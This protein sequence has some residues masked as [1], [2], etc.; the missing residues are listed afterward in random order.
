M[1]RKITLR[2]KLKR[3]DIVRTRQGEVLGIVVRQETFLGSKGHYA[4]NK[5]P[6]DRKFFREYKVDWYTRYHIT[7]LIRM[8]AQIITRNALAV[9]QKKKPSREL[10][11]LLTMTAR[12]NGSR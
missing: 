4:F 11:I 5:Q 7:T 2:T 1:A 9:M 10:E 8:R 12:R 6:G 3:G